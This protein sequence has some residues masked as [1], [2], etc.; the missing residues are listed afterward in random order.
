[1][2][3]SVVAEGRMKTVK[4]IERDEVVDGKEPK[5][6][7]HT[8]HHGHN[9]NSD[10]H[11]AGDNMDDRVPGGT[12]NKYAGKEDQTLG[13]ERDNYADTKS[14]EEVDALMTT[15]MRNEQFSK[16]KVWGGYA[17]DPDETDMD[18]S[19]FDISPAPQSQQHLWIRHHDALNGECTL[20]SG[21]L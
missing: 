7:D 2:A 9:N 1:M 5:R 16:K 20:R 3:Q 14:E 4:E 17:T 10:L 13:E 11:N 6:D 8:A 12:N 18:D 21:M 15:M 19:D